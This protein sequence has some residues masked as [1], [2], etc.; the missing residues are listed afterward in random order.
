M[1]S[2]IRVFVVDKNELVRHSIC[3]ILSEF[4]EIEIIGQSDMDEGMISLC[5][6][7]KPDVILLDI[8]EVSRFDRLE[9]VP[10]LKQQ[11]PETQ[12]IAVSSSV[13]SA[14]IPYLFGNG[15][16]GFFNKVG[17]AEELVT[18]IQTVYRGEQYICSNTPRMDIKGNVW[19]N[20][21]DL[22]S[23]KEL[24]VALLL[25]SPMDTKEIRIEMHLGESTFK[26]YCTRIYEKL[27]IKNR[28]ELVVLA[29]RYG[30]YMID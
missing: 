12:I 14:T 26:T 24:D 16:S 30:L 17:D 28:A 29:R 21:F 25:C 15:V 13:G 9:I 19:I 8:G 3:S 10:D 18:A 1:K 11:L 6:E 22:L 23:E 7:L 2:V 4:Q 20:P 27:S 5:L